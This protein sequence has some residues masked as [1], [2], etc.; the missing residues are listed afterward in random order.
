[1]DELALQRERLL[2]R[3]ALLRERIAD[4]A[5]VLAAP[6]RTADRVRDGFAWLRDHPLVPLAAVAAVV[7]WRPRRALRLAMRVV[8]GWRL[9]RRVRREWQSWAAAVVDR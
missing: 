1:M 3:S 8:W 9:W 7:A 6:L 5:R 4:D 2:T